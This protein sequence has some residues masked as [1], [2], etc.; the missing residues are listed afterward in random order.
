MTRVLGGWGL[1]VERDGCLFV[2]ERRLE[3]TEMLRSQTDK[4]KAHRQLLLALLGIRQYTRQAE[5]HL[6][7]AA[8]CRR[9]RA[10]ANRPPPN[11]SSR[12]RLASSPA[13]DAV[14][15]AHPRHLLIVLSP[16]VVVCSK[17]GAL[18]CDQGGRCVPVMHHARAT[19]QRPEQH[20]Q[21]RPAHEAR[22]WHSLDEGSM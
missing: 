10:A 22:L 12:T 19:K 20:T 8:R 5:K 18:H 15:L 17:T 6:V 21:R 7:L 14:V 9:L 3:S 11:P 1:G 16:A 4:K 2:L 13:R